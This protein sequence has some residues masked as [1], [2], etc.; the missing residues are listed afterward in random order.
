M[1][2]DYSTETLHLLYKL[3]HCEKKQRHEIKAKIYKI[4]LEK[5][6]REILKSSNIRQE[7]FEK[8]FKR[9]EVK[10]LTE[11]RLPQKALT[12]RNSLGN[13]CARLHTYILY[14]LLTSSQP[15]YW[16]I[17]KAIRLSNP[18]TIAFLKNEFNAKSIT[19][20]KYT[21]TVTR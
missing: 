6:Q 18:A 8:D 21:K 3:K 15:C 12:N 4:E 11:R 2:N 7:I 20:F 9:V 14:K 13:K 17:E 16:F 10:I 5:I 19:I 1:L